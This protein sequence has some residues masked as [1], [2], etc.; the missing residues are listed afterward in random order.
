MRNMSFSLTT[1]AVRNRTKDVTR[2][3]GWSNLKPGE[4]FWAVEKSMGLKKGEK[5]KKICLLEC[6]SNSSENLLDLPINL[7]KKMNSQK[8]EIEREGF[9]GW[10]PIEFFT[11]FCDTHYS[12][13]KITNQM[14]SEAKVNRIEFQY[15]EDNS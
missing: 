11:F 6:L 1:E 2:R 10:S 13:S 5:I 8:T 14:L 15:V 7:Q 4:L 12:K 3:I 9:P